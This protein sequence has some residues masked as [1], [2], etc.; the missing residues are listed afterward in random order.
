[1]KATVLARRYA[2]ALFELAAE[3]KALETIAKE[4]VSFQKLLSGSPELHYFFL[5]PEAGKTGKKKLIE[6]NFQDR[7]STLF[8]NFMFVLLEKGRQHIFEE[9][10]AEFQ[11]FFDKH[12]NRMHAAT[13]T[14]VPMSEKDK[15]SLQ[16]VLTNQYKADFEVENFVDPEIL[17]GLILQVEGKVFDASVR[18]QL[19]QLKG[20]MRQQ[21][22]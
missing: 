13:T 3:K 7:Y 4:V 16:S 5:S 19:D 6:N 21:Q 2:K 14:A 11:R 20:R 15:T 17:G 8:V 18:N 12:L 22:N 1:M 9:V 10:A